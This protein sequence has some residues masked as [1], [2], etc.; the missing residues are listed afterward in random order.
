M[1]IVESSDGVESLAKE[2]RIKESY[3]NIFGFILSSE[4]VSPLEDELK[5]KPKETIRGLMAKNIN[6][7]LDADLSIYLRVIV[8]I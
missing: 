4:F 3:K 5:N 2:Y 7:I 8:N 6:L 1:D